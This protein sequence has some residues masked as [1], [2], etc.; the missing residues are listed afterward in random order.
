LDTVISK[1]AGEKLV[2][3]EAT[4]DK[5]R[6]ERVKLSVPIIVM[7]ETPEREEIRE[8]T[9]TITVNAHGGLFKLKTE[10]LHGQPII[11]VNETTDM[12]VS[13]RVVR[14]EDLPN[15]EFGVAFE[16]DRPAPEFW[17]VTFPPAD[18]KIGSS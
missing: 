17:L 16:F 13:C 2:G 5:R 3:T 12:Q 6:S 4:R 9:H 8:N 18:W 14:V 11:L 15:G 10:L 1:N 7:T